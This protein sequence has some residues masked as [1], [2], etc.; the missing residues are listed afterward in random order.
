MFFQEGGEIL[1]ILEIERVAGRY[2]DQEDL[3]MDTG[4]I[5]QPAESDGFDTLEESEDDTIMKAM[6]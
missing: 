2:G 4:W 5:L 3:V 6:G 1:Y